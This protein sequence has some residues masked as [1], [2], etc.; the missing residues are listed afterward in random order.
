MFEKAARLG[1]RREYEDILIFTASG[2]LN[3][4]FT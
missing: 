2:T 1:S 3:M 4:G